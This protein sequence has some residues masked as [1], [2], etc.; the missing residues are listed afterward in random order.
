[1]RRVRV[2]IIAVEKQY[3]L[4]ILSVCLQ[5]V[6]IQHAMCMRRIILL[7]ACLTLRYFSTLS[8]KQHNF[9]KKLLS[10]KC[11]LLFSLQLLSEVFLILGRIQ[12]DIINIHKVSCKVPV[13]LV[14]F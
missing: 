2:T 11:V 12:R 6:V 9:R 7:K 13:I 5:S 4:H 8:H 1:M 3:V 10:I 14:K